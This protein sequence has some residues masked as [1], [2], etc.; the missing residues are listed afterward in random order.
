MELIKLNNT[1]GYKNFIEDS[2]KN[3]FLNQISENTEIFKKNNVG[4]N[5]KFLTLKNIDY[6]KNQ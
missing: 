2:E 6:M 5:R 3:Y 4:D 1:Y